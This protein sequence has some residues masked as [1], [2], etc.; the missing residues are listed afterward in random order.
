[1]I[2]TKCVT[3][4]LLILNGMSPDPLAGIETNRTGSSTAWWNA[5]ETF[6]GHSL[7][8]DG[9]LESQQE[10]A[11]FPCCGLPTTVPLFGVQAY[12]GILTGRLAVQVLW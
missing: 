3:Y 6:L 11:N 8:L 2:N 5:A 10:S 4:Q 7:S 9:Y 12:V 1:M